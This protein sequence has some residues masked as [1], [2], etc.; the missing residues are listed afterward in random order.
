MS[1]L[2]QVSRR[3]LE[4]VQ[5]FLRLESAGGLLLL[6]AAALGMIFANSPLA[7]IY[8]GA[9][10][11]HLTVTLGGI[12]VDKPIALWI[13]DGL[14]AVFFLLVGLELKRE[15]LEGQF[16]DR[17]QLI[18]P[19]ACAVGGMAVPM[20]IYAAFNHDSLLRMNGL[21]IPAATDIAFALGVLSLLGSRVPF[22]LKMLLTAVAVL[23]DLGAIVIIALFYTHELSTVSLVIAGVALA[24]LFALNRAGVTRLSP[25]LVLGVVLWLAVLKSGVH[26][27]L[28]GVALGM[29]IPLRGARDRGERPLE[30]VEHALHPWVAYLILPVFAFANAGVS[31]DGIALSTL[32]GPVPMGIALGLLLGKPIGVFGA[33]AVVVMFGMARKPEGL[34]WP[35]LLGMAMLCGIGFTMSL[36]IGG[37][38]FDSAGDELMVANRLG[39]LGGSL[40]AA[41]VG[42][43]FLRVCLPM[44]SPAAASRPKKRS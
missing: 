15:M 20:A 38:A 23:D 3:A 43:V 1:E 2:G 4:A 14:M 26:A 12:G 44:P 25:Y 10:N 11:T 18:L 19:L 17:A 9:L 36:F 7:A 30:V 40:A 27:T 32:L 29:A 16:A 41:I 33:A 35:A 22:A 28:A 42:F 37:L 39:I 6:A 21:P 24:I 8:H 31:L 5:E 34:S 13:N